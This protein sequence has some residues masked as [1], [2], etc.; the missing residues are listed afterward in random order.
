MKSLEIIKNQR[1]KELRGFGFIIFNEEQGYLKA[2]NEVQTIKGRRV[3]SQNF[4]YTIQHINI[5]LNLITKNPKFLFL[6]NIRL[7]AN[8]L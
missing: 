3:I 2:I 5:S 8:Q 7:N 4:G 6:K 1:T